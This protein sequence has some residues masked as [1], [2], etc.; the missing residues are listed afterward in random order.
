MYYNPNSTSVHECPMEVNLS[1]TMTTILVRRHD[2]RS[3]TD[4]LPLDLAAGV[5]SR[6]RHPRID[7]PCALQQQ[8]RRRDLPGWSNERVRAA[9]VGGEEDARRHGRRE[10]DA[11]RHGRRRRRCAPPRSEEKKMRAA[12]VGGRE[13]RA[14]T[15]GGREMRAAMVELRSGAAWRRRHTLRVRLRVRAIEFRAV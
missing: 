2:G 5:R 8:I 11:R 10:G 15:V 3:Q 7:T 9:T 13:M 14:A 6:P 4:I 12:T 1:R